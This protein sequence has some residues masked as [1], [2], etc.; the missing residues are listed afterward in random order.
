MG[1]STPGLPVRSHQNIGFN[2]GLVF[3][4]N[5]WLTI[6][7]SVWHDFYQWL[8]ITM[9]YIVCICSVNLVGTG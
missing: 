2:I 9:A 4:V 1:K 8:S 5:I 6:E 7:Y 3:G